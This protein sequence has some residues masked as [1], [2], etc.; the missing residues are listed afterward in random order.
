MFNHSSHRRVGVVFAIL[1]AGGMG[2]A[3]LVP[4]GSRVAAWLTI[5]EARANPDPTC[6]NTACDNALSCSYSPGAE[7]AL[8]PNS[9]S[10]QWCKS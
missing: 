9:C 1:V 7:C 8:S 6:T 10:D 3:D 5:V 4:G 2:A